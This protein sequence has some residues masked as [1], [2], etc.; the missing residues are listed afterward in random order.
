MNQKISQPRS[1]ADP[2]RILVTNIAL[3][4]RSGTDTLVRDHVL[5]LRRRGHSVVTF[6]PT[7]GRA[8]AEIR[9][10]GSPVATSLAA[11]GETPDIIH[12]HHNGPTMAALTRFPGTPATGERCV[13]T[14]EDIAVSA[15]IETFLQTH[16][17]YDRNAHKL[18]R[19]VGAI[20]DMHAAI[21]NLAASNLAM[22]DEIRKLRR[23]GFWRG[24]QRLIRLRSNDR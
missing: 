18:L 6:S 8:A 9:A 1:A 22:G 15:F 13:A 17:I 5:A 12:G 16:R 10:T 14:D 11:I 21:D 4:G 19:G 23:K 24:L 7:I 20:E 3:H 2:L